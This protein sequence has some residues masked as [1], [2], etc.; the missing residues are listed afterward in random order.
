M[1]GDTHLT[2]QLI[3]FSAFV[4]WTVRKSPPVSL[5]LTIKRIGRE[6]KG[7][8]MD[9]IRVWAWGI[10]GGCWMY[11][12]DAVRE[13]YEQAT[14]RMKNDIK[15]ASAWDG[16]GIEEELYVCSFCVRHIS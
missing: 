9:D 2:G 11:F 10:D 1:H 6:E 13:I 8:V 12:H 4:R 15:F 14:R 16:R 5:S 3:Y 7:K